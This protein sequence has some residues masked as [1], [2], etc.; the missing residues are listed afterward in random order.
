LDESP[1]HYLILGVLLGLFFFFG[2]TNELESPYARLHAD[3]PE[4][5]IQDFTRIPK[6]SLV[7]CGNGSFHV[8]STLNSGRCNTSEILG[9]YDLAIF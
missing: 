5:D 7:F 1:E 3:S 8:G 4:I 9:I 2:L 6:E